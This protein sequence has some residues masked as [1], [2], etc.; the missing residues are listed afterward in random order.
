M[1]GIDGSEVFHP[2]EVRDVG[3]VVSRIQSYHQIDHSSGFD[4][5]SGL[6]LTVVV[7]LTEDIVRRNI[8]DIGELAESKTPGIEFSLGLPHRVSHQIR[9][10][11][12]LGM[13]GIDG[14]KDPSSFLDLGAGL[15]ILAVDSTFGHPPDI[16]GVRYLDSQ[17][18]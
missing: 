10:G 12:L 15:R 14:Q 7:N 13:Q 6:Y 5:L 1:Y 4:L 3:L 2:L 17:L 18:V 9:H 8:A 11:D 16:D